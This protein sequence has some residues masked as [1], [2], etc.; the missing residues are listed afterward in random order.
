M[1]QHSAEDDDVALTSGENFIMPLDVPAVRWIRIRVLR[2]WTGGD[3]FQIGELFVFGDN[4][5]EL[6]Q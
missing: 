5:S 3:N 4:R 1:G 6:Y 2:T